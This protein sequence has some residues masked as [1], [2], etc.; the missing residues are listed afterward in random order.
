MSFMNWMQKTPYTYSVILFKGFGFQV[1]NFKYPHKNIASVII[2]CLGPKK[3]RSIFLTVWQTHLSMNYTVMD[4][5]CGL[6]GNVNITYLLCV[7][8]VTNK[9]RS[10]TIAFFSLETQGGKSIPVE[11]TEGNVNQIP[12]SFRIKPKYWLFG[13]SGICS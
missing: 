13:D 8:S 2:R 10:F 5:G 4:C 9:I 11:C 1:W 6:V 7:L 3:T 12:Y